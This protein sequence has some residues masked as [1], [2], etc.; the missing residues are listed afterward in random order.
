MRRLRA[1][2]RSGIIPKVLLGG[3]RAGEAEAR[4]GAGAGVRAV[5]VTISGEWREP[6]PWRI[7]SHTRDI[8]MNVYIPP[9]KYFKMYT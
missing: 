7:A 2:G 3:G 8:D 5:E 1:E 9:L 6:F 4:A